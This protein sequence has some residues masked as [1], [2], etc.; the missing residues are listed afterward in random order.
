VDANFAQKASRTNKSFSDEGIARYSELTGRPINTVS[1]L[2][3]ALKLGEIKPSQLPLDFV[4]LNGTRLILNTRTSTALDQAG[5]PRI[6]WYGVDKTNTKVYDGV[7]FIDLAL[8]LLRKNK[9]P[10]T[11]RYEK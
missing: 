10:S 6:E 4:D 11:G 5:I 9:Y 2:T 7:T 3:D 1:D 8:E